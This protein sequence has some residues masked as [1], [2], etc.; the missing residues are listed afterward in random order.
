MMAFVQHRDGPHASTGREKAI[1]AEEERK[2]SNRMDWYLN[3]AHRIA[4]MKRENIDILGERKSRGKRIYGM[5]APV[6][7]NTLLNYFKIGP[8]TI[9][10]LVE[11]NELRRNLFSPRHAY[12][13]SDGKRNRDC[14]RRLL[15]PRM[16]FQA[17]DSK[18]SCRSF[19]PRS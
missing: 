13:D 5:G 11:K 9:D 14:A 10:F 17:R 15:C 7:G 16:E 19:G 18:E 4:R 8:D 12:P 3:F 1:L 6:K 2:G